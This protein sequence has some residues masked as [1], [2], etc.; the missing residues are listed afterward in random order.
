MVSSAEL[1]TDRFASRETARGYGPLAAG[2]YLWLGLPLMFLVRLALPVTGY[3]G[4]LLVG[5]AH[6]ALLTVVVRRRQRQSG[7]RDAALQLANLLLVLGP[8]V[9]FFGAITGSPN[10][11]DAVGYTWNTIGVATGSLV[12]TA[13]LVALATSL[14]A[15]GN[16]WSRR[17][18]SSRS[19]W[20]R[21]SGFPRWGSGLPCW[22]LAPATRGRISS[23][24]MRT[25]GAPT[26]R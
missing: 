10:P 6:L 26:R 9:F 18:P 15:R 7:A 12:T 14:W 19:S 23:A 25:S 13:G 3:R 4:V 16:A 1:T 21:R 24:S 8:A 2:A 17:L 5:F 11:V 22:P 20:P